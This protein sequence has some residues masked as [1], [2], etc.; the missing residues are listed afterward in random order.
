MVSANAVIFN[1][2]SG[3]HVSDYHGDD[4]LRLRYVIHP[5]ARYWPSSVDLGD[6]VFGDVS[7]QRKAVMNGV[8]KG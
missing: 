3:D 6:Q 5:L 1:S 2:G 7:A 8:F 4:D